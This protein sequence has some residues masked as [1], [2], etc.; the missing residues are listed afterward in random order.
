M[1]CIW[2]KTFSAIFFFANIL[3]LAFLLKFITDFYYFFLCQAKSQIYFT[4]CYCKFI[5]RE[6]SN[7]PLESLFTKKIFMSGGKTAKCHIK[8]QRTEQKSLCP[9]CHHHSAEIV[10][11]SLQLF[12]H[13]LCLQSCWK[14]A[15]LE[16]GHF[17]LTIHNNIALLYL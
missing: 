16:F 2:K 1:L 3:L 9:D 17:L 4:Q 13:R 8:Q 14:F 11:I 15:R 7:W 5:L 12:R 10:F 6:F